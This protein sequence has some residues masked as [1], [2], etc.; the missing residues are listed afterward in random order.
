MKKFVLILIVLMGAL[1]L[2]ACVGGTAARGGTSWPGLA[3][4]TER[5]Y[6]AD[7]SFVYAVDLKDG[8]QLW[9][10]PGKASASTLFFAPPVLTDDGQLLVGSEGNDHA[11]YS[12]DPK[13]GKEKWVKPVTAKDRWVASSL[14]HDGK[15]Y[16][17]NADGNLYIISMDGQVETK[18]AVG[19]ALWST[20]VTDGTSIYVTS[21]D[22]HFHSVDIA[23]QKVTATVDMG[24]AIPGGLAVGSNGV[25]VGSF[26][27]KLDVVM[28]GQ[29]RS[30]AEADNW[31][32]GAPIV[33]GDTVYYADLSG[34]LYS[35]DVKAEK[36]NWTVKP[37]DAIVASPLF[38]GDKV[39]VATE[40]GTVVAYDK[41]SKNVWTRTVGGKIYSNLVSTGDLILVSPVSADFHVA[42]LDLDGKLVWTFTP[43]K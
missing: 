13:T 18:L 42:A 15:I 30:L 39:I 14:V 8:K 32:W 35:L 4:D 5:A 23:S 1:T 38:D 26:T 10:Y 20:P 36:L 16:A 12:L 40:A 11:L 21:L 7:G 25:Y 17:P 19:G 41:D 22:H 3:A 27:K 34:N 28:N 6:V 29:H 31:I 24:G 9:S 33:D 43:E 37:D 2:S